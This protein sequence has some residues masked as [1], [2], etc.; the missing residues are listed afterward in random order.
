MNRKKFLLFIL[1]AFV[2]GCVSQKEWEKDSKPYFF[3]KV[4]KDQNVIYF[5]GSFHVGKKE[6]YPLPVRVRDSFHA[7][8]ALAVEVDVESESELKSAQNTHFAPLNFKGL[9]S[10]LNQK[11]IKTFERAIEGTGKTFHEFESLPPAMTSIILSQIAA[12]K[13]GYDSK[14]GIDVHFLREARKQKKR[15]ISLESVQ[16]QFSLLMNLSLPLQKAMLFQILDHWDD[17]PKELDELSLQWQQ[18]NGSEILDS[19]EM[20]NSELTANEA[21]DFEEKFLNQR[22]FKMVD[23]IEKHTNENKILFVVVGAAHLWGEKGLINLMAQKKYIVER[24]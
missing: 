4:T 21:R 3:Y 20:N 7:S 11:Q 22:N 12:E 18:G 9:K 8:H 16:Q 2:F 1:T 13:A 24:L 15:I 10:T 5:F 23:N 14:Y 17:F 6:F 19:Q